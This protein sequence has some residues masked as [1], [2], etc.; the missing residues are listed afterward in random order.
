MYLYLLK[1]LKCSFILF[2]ELFILSWS[3]KSVFFRF[4]KAPTRF[5]SWQLDFLEGPM[6]YPAITTLIL[7]LYVTFLFLKE[8]VLTKSIKICFLFFLGIIIFRDLCIYKENSLIKAT[9]Y[10]YLPNIGIILP[11]FR[12]LCILFVFFVLCRSYRDD[13]MEVLI[14]TETGTIIN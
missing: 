3:K 13:T 1:I 10:I 4:Q 5:V 8:N 14:S 9:L 12:C 6:K 7:G 11:F 2:K